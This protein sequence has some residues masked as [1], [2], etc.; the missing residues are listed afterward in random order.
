MRG[1]RPTE[2]P[3]PDRRHLRVKIGVYL[4]REDR[5]QKGGEEAISRLFPG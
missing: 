1:S 4:V 2:T 3:R 5:P